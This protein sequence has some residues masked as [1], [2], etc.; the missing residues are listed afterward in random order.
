MTE[1]W[2]AVVDGVQDTRARVH[3]KQ[4]SFSGL[5]TVTQY[6]LGRLID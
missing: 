4:L 5:S 6:L 2:K 3:M 1:A